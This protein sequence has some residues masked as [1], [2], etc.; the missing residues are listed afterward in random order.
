MAVKKHLLFPVY[1][2]LGAAL[3]LLLAACGN[4]SDCR[5]P[6][7]SWTN[8]EGQTLVFENDGRV[9]WL[10]KF[11]SS[12]DTTQAHFEFDCRE[13]PASIDIIDFSNGPFKG[14]T[15]YGLLEWSSDTSFR[16]QYESGV[17][18]SERPKAFDA[19]LSQDFFELR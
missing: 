7:G 5:V 15:V 17:D 12:F 11:G 6:N 18:P 10:T 9:L 4:G 1:A 3:S 8:R 19:E 16:L 14:K 13:T 2:A